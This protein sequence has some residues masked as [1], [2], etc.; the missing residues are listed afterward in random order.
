MP[1]P[2]SQRP[3]RARSP[4]PMQRPPRIQHPAPMQI[5][6]TPAESRARGSSGARLPRPPRAGTPDKLPRP[7]RTDPPVPAMRTAGVDS[8]DSVL[9]PNRTEPPTSIQRPPRTE[10]PPP[11][12]DLHSTIQRPS[13][14]EFPCSL[15]RP[16]RIKPPLP[17]D[18]TRTAET[19]VIKQ[20][21]PNTENSLPLQ[22]PPRI[23]PPAPH[24]DTQAPFYSTTKRVPLSQRPARIDH[25]CAIQRTNMTE[26]KEVST[27]NPLDLRTSNSSVRHTGGGI[28]ELSLK[29]PDRKYV[30]DP[31][32][33]CEEASPNLQCLVKSLDAEEPLLP[34]RIETE[35]SGGTHVV[36]P[37]GQPE[38]TAQRDL[39]ESDELE[40]DIG[41]FISMED[42]DCE[43][44]EQRRKKG[45]IA[46]K[47]KRENLQDEAE[48][49]VSSDLNNSLD[50]SLE[51]RAKLHNLTAVNVRNI[52]HEVITNEHVVAM[53]K[54]AITDT[55]DLPVFEPKMTRSK[56]KEVVEKGVVIPTWN[57]S[58]IKKV[59]EQKARQFVDITLEE[60][61]SSEDEEYCPEKEEEEEEDE[62]AEESLLESDVESTASSPRGH[63]RPRV[64]HLS[65]P[66]E[67]PMDCNPAAEI[68]PE[69][70][71]H[72]ESE[73]PVMGPPPPPL[74]MKCIQDI[75]FMDE[76]HAV[77]EELNS[78]TVCMDSF[79]TICPDSLIA[80]RT[81]SKRPLKNVPIGQLE[82]KLMAPDITPDMYDPNTADDEDWK[83]W[84]CS[85]MQDD[86]GNEDEADDDDD[87]EYNILEDLDEPDT[88]DFRND[89]AVR[90]TKKEVSELMEELFDTFQDEL[91]YSNLEEEEVEDDDSNQGAAHNRSHLE[92]EE[93]EDSK[94]EHI[95]NFNIPQAIR[96]EEPLA[97]IITEQHRTVKAKLQFLRMKKTVLK[98]PAQV[99][100][101]PKSL[102]APEYEDR[103]AIEPK[104]PVV[105]TLN[106]GQ[107]QRL[108][109]QMQQHVQ[110]LTQLNLLSSKNPGL[111]F[112]TDT[113]R[114]FLVELSS[115]A[116][117]SVL[118]HRPK[119]PV[120]QSMFQAS[121]L[122]DAMQLHFNF[123]SQVP[124]NIEPP[125]LI[126]KN[127][128]EIP[129]LPTDIAWILAT[130]P[131]FMYPELLP[132]CGLKVRG[133]RD[134]V[135][136]TKGEDSLL[137]LGLK[138]FDGME[139]YKTLISKYLIP[140]KTSQQLKAHIKNATMQ[141]SQDNII[142]YL[143]RNKSLPD[144][145]KCC[146][147]IQAYDGKPP[148]DREKHRL[149]FWLKASMTSIEK[150]MK[151][152]ERDSQISGTERLTTKYPLVA[153]REL[154]LT[155]KP[156]PSPFVRKIWRQ[157]KH[158]L[159]PLLIRPSS[160]TNNN[161]N[162]TTNKPLLNQSSDMQ[163]LPITI[164]GQMPS[165]NQS[166]R[167]VQGI[168]GV[169]SVCVPSDITNS[170]VSS[171]PHTPFV[172]HV[173]LPQPT[174]MVPA[175]T[176]QGVQKPSIKTL[177]K[178]PCSQGTP[179]IHSTP[180]IFTVPNGALKLVSLGTSCGVIQ[181]IGTRPG[182]PVTT[183]LLN[184]SS[185]KQTLITSPFNQTLFDMSP[186]LR[187]GQR[188]VTFETI[189]SDP[190]KSK[191]EHDWGCVSINMKNEGSSVSEE[192]NHGEPNAGEQQENCVQSCSPV[193]EKLKCD[194]ED[195]KDCLLDSKP[196]HI[197]YCSDNSVL[198]DLASSDC[199]PEME[200]KDKAVQ[201][202]LM[203]ELHSLQESDIKKEDQE[204]FDVGTSDS[205][206][207]HIVKIEE[208]CPPDEG[209]SA[210]AANI[211]Q[212]LAYPEIKK[213]EDQWDVGICD[214]SSSQLLKTEQLKYSEQDD[215]AQL[216]DQAEAP[217]SD[218][219]AEPADAPMSDP[220]AEPA[221]APMSDPPA[222]P[223]DAP[224]S[225]PPAEPADAPMSD[226]PAEP[227]DAP[228]SDSPAEPAD[229]PMSDPPAEPAD[230]P[231]S[232]PPAEPADA[233]MSDPPAEPADAPMS[234]PPAEPADAPMSDPPAEPAAAPVPDP[235]A[236][237][238]AAPVPDPPAEPAA[239]P[240]PDPPA[241]PAAAPVPD[242]PAEPAAAPVP[243]PP[244]EPAAAPV[245][246]LPAEPAAAPVPES[247]AEP[248]AAPVP[249][250][251]AEPAAA[252]VP[253]P[254][255]EPA[256]APVPDPPAEPA[257]APVP[258]PP[259]EPAA[260][261][262]PDPPAEP[263]AAP[264]PDPPAEP[265]AAPVP[266]PPAEPAA[267]PVPDPPAEPA[268]APVPDPPAE[269]AAAPVPDPP[270][271]P[272]AAPVPDPPAEPAAAPVPDPPAEPA[273]A[274]VPDP[275]AEPACAALYDP[276][277]EP[278]AA[279]VPDLPADAAMSDPPAEPADGAMS[280]PPAEPA[281]GAMSDPPAEPADGAMSDPPAEPADGAMSDPPAE[282]ADA[283]MSDPPA[284]PA[285]P[286]MSDPPAEPADGAMSDPPAEPADGAMSDPPAEPADGAMSDPPAEP[287]DGAMSDPPAEPADAIGP[288]IQ[289]SNTER[290]NEQYPLLKEKEYVLN[291]TQ[292]QDS[293]GQV[294]SPQNTPP[295]MNGDVDMSSP[296]EMPQD[297]SSPLGQQDGS[298][299]KDL[300]EEEEEE[301]FDDLTQDEDEEEM[302]SASEESVL[303]V[304]ELQE[305]MEKLTWLASERRLS[306]EGDSEENSQEENSEPEDEEEEEEVEGAE[307][308]TRK[309]EEMTDEVTAESTTPAPT[310]PHI[311]SPVPMESSAAPA[312]EV[313]K[314]G[315]KGRT[316]HRVRSRRGRARTS[317][318]ASKLLHLYDENILLKDPLREQKDM[319]F[320]KEYLNRV[321]EALKVVPGKYEQF[322]HLIYQFET[323]KDTRT[324]VDLYENLRKI[325]C[326][327]P[328]LLKD[329]AAFLLPEQALEC[330]LFQE[331]Q[332]FEKSRTFL[333]QLEICFLEN[334]AQHQK[335]IK[336]LQSFAE[337]PLQEISKL[338]AQMCQL[339]K[340][341][342][343]L[344]EEFSLF[345]DHLRPPASRMGEFE[346]LNWTEDKDYKF[347][348]FEEVSL[349][350]IEEE[351]E[352]SKVQP[353]QRSK[354]KKDV[355][356]IQ[357]V[358]WVD[359]GKDCPCS[360]HEV[361][362]EQRLKRCKRRMCNQCSNKVCENR[363][364]RSK[365][366][367]EGV[368]GG[369]QGAARHASSL[370][371]AGRKEDCEGRLAGAKGTPLA[372]GLMAGAKGTVGGRAS[373]IPDN[374]VSTSKSRNTGCAVYSKR[375]PP[376]LGHKSGRK[377]LA[378]TRPDPDLPSQ[379]ALDSF[380]HLP[381]SPPLPPT[382]TSVTAAA[383]DKDNMESIP[384]CSTSQKM[385]STSDGSQETQESK[386]VYTQQEKCSEKEEQTLT[387]C[388]KNITVS[389]SGEKV[390]LWTR[391]ADRV[392][393]TMCQEKGAQD[394]T[395]D[396]I[397][398][399]LGNKTPAEVCQRFRELVNLFLAACATSSDEEE[400]VAEQISDED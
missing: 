287:A 154:Q 316:A 38:D 58:P 119:N 296:S 355:N 122:R 382:C 376:T 389:S 234:D 344:Q 214:S 275:P 4:S 327:W 194:T 257:A 59:G 171:A 164:L 117:N 113:T 351:E 42:T 85:L 61:D 273:A 37:S 348:G 210:E 341:H 184:P 256:A 218:P 301:D 199:K 374:V 15:Q 220:P 80:L 267:A 188:S 300:P 135:Y 312:G 150:E 151:K 356:H 97:N 68:V 91:G 292:G 107:R 18:R 262:V 399:K 364:Q 387:V 101:E 335:I 126:K 295:C 315:S 33:G 324:A 284:E 186:V 384:S 263:A 318:D 271:E 285:I 357:D 116:E 370:K 174:I 221:D 283:T 27:I 279:P 159:K 26:N 237:P 305:T 385:D 41:L 32:I 339:L 12:L 105:L 143:K 353:P 36:Q 70:G 291:E 333:R 67:E 136:F 233:P 340:G 391:E 349:P 386:D 106:A 224:M 362:G 158:N 187:E 29:N 31:E 288:D 248:A 44:G 181:S 206:S 22:R 108:Q 223:A 317:K 185:V 140:G 328:K 367:L 60:E 93:D 134:K 203:V 1:S 238:A 350:D 56:L 307:S 392:I 76:L 77:D 242:P 255:A 175:L 167:P 145:A 299:E 383:D 112:E 200:S 179:L 28:T 144:L 69:L 16:P 260:A 375:K 207:I 90:I 52:L 294:E 39:C 24:V 9:R 131:V 338:K 111:S 20:R 86:V 397:S 371:E 358:D 314:G 21:P 65:E 88:E 270:A 141:K 381:S 125:K 395:F 230:A 191:K 253:D 302:S 94:Q 14:P 231:M 261:P 142:K 192:G 71:E 160:S 346:V 96:F 216:P 190:G 208:D 2:T 183:V 118:T 55:Q 229:A 219:P 320:A 54:A 240:V 278:A 182:I 347:D 139:F 266:D 3:P 236:E 95:P 195:R 177:D 228:M 393:L 280:D 352:G 45:R 400:E 225:D 337:C 245:P 232:D 62:T 48:A 146:D 30:S 269:P 99:P 10:P 326:D 336:L 268:A 201:I 196:L 165:L 43:D 11:R 363:T 309:D 204:E 217:M 173:P 250:P 114:L 264:V 178:T 149:P 49:A 293:A 211:S 252:P 281:D 378:V 176:R 103:L 360:C 282:P 330:G 388:A 373:S 57:L 63:K 163:P 311:P 102:H 64:H 304:P 121:N 398:S 66:T 110:L 396:A 359:G 78:S 226:P 361:G 162:N 87:P 19:L 329:F 47:R 235:P 35:P 366:M 251:P 153:P 128:S 180:V 276:P 50:R 354:R 249:D 189:L 13:W 323:N 345:F 286:A 306:Q 172:T 51:D 17:M 205:S 377:S 212:T 298:N 166:T 92:E 79:Q 169:N 239:A 5:P 138:H 8:L 265:A 124:E 277:A 274:P 168:V 308:S 319:A 147:I 82:A 259:A 343:H 127:G 390:I 322:L 334:P 246:D 247:S 213:D 133:P 40:D 372:D 115:F 209:N 129:S 132:T 25:L 258:D 53:M 368:S 222:E 198:P 332:A 243:D 157:R 6:L 394:E 89:R 152:T 289:D 148:V 379:K 7:A 120:F 155:L 365:E 109:Q 34:S 161:N 100:E 331:Q 303:S 72:G 98:P 137:A 310:H 369:P 272:A 321:R 156:L 290:R 81:R 227:A 74:K 73:V 215:H 23:K 325:L 244:A 202:S 193:A 313:R 75:T 380:S 241:E 83:M 342:H 46:L 254:P 84:L 170:I 104:A 297:S 197:G 123:H 130:Q